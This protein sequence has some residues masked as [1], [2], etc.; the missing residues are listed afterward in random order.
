MS[1]QTFR[2][3][4]RDEF[5]NIKS[6]NIDINVTENFTLSSQYRYEE[7]LIIKLFAVSN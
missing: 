4:D 7:S 6:T 5:V 1:L 2:R 3:N